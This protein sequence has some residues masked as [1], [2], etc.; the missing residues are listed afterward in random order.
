[1]KRILLID[2]DPSVR[3]V[4]RR[5]LESDGYQV[6]DAADGEIGLEM[7]RQEPVDLVITDVVMPNV[8][9]LEVIRQLRRESSEVRIIAITGYAPSRLTLARELGADLT[10]TKPVEMADLLKAVQKAL[11]LVPQDN[12]E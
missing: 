8:Y 12:T 4:I 5:L 1:M 6:L 9:G 3:R 10:L 2:D 7:Y 11:N